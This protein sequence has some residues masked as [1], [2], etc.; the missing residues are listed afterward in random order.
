MPLW[1][2]KVRNHKSRVKQYDSAYREGSL[3]VRE[4]AIEIICSAALGDRLEDL[5]D[6]S[7]EL[8]EFV[9]GLLQLDEIRTWYAG[10]FRDTDKGI[11][12]E[13]IELEDILIARERLG[14]K[15]EHSGDGQTSHETK[16]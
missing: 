14:V 13:V 1:R 8:W 3:S 12:E 4:A 9:V 2:R 16:K 11:I 5:D 15:V 6:L 7:P 10:T